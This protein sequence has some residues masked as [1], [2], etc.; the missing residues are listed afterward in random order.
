MSA[1]GIKLSR[2]TSTSRQR[3]SK[4]SF[5]FVDLGNNSERSLSRGR[6]AFQSSG[7]GGIGNIRQASL[8]RDAR[9]G[10]G[11]DDFS[12]TRGREPHVHP[13]EPFYSTGRGGAG[14]I[15]SP[16]RDPSKPDPTEAADERVVHEHIV[17]DETVPHSTGRGGLG[18]INH[19]RSRSRDNR[20]NAS[21]ST[22]HSSG[23]GGAGNIHHGSAILPDVIDEEERHKL[24]HP[25]SGVHSTGRGGA[26]NVTPAHEPNVEHHK[27]LAHDYESTG[28]GGVGNIVH[29]EN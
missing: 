3:E 10:T 13:G 18:N 23:R 24:G 20:T 1:L 29:S 26:A 16:S 2:S 9:P 22:L 6:E 27:H 14:N 17:A 15:R 7:R 12:P 11:P 25:D 19:S 21:S 5:S 8:S 4:P 28:R